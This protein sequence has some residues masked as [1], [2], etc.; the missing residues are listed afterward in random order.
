LKS[1][2]FIFVYFLRFCT[3]CTNCTVCT[4][5]FG[6]ASIAL[7]ALGFH[8][9]LRW[10]LISFCLTLG[11]SYATP[12]GVG[13]AWFAPFA[14]VAPVFNVFKEQ[15]DMEKSGTAFQATIASFASF[16]LVAL[17]FQVPSS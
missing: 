11:Y 9:P 10:S 4:G 6:F 8:M 12:D 16:A 15:V 7:F 14:L 3:V 5:F 1:D 17:V 13:F 2:A